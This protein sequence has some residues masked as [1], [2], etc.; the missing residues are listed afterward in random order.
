[1]HRTSVIRSRSNPS[2]PRL[3]KAHTLSRHSRK[4]SPKHAKQATRGPLS[5]R[6]WE[7]PEKRHA[8]D[9]G[10]GAST[11]ARAASE[12]T[13]LLGDAAVAVSRA[14]RHRHCGRHT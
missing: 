5:A 2:G 13:I 10:R 11:D 1:P 3:P 4:Q 7:P 9:T 14:T 12:V 6:S 8:S